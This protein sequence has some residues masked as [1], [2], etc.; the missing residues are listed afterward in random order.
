MFLIYGLNLLLI[1]QHSKGKPCEIK[2]S[3]EII[4]DGGINILD[5]Y[6]RM[7]D[8]ELDCLS[9]DETVEIF[10]ALTDNGW[11]WTLQGHCGRTAKVLIEAGYCHV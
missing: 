5:L 4:N 9:N 3:L 11:A 7:I 2:S 1:R 6:D 10:Q 8:Y